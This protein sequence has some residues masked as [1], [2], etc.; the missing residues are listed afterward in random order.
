M[1]SSSEQQWL[2]SKLAV[3][4]GGL[5]LRTAADHGP[6]AYVVSVLTAKELKLQMLGRNAMDGLPSQSQQGGG[7]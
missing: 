3:A 4:V 6:A 2:Q 7:G 1:Y 5:G